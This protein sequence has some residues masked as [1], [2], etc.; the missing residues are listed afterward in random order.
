MPA[1]ERADG[2]WMS[3]STPIIQWFEAAYTTPAV[4]PQDPLQRFFS[5]L[6]E[7]YA[8][9]WLWRPAMHYRWHYEQGARL[10]SHYL[11]NE[12]GA[13]LPLPVFQKRGVI[14]RRQR[15]DYTTGDGITTDQVPGVEYHA[16]RLPG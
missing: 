7:D 1:L 4:I 9:E 16:G 3:D 12:I 5:L 15:N 8:D 2:R 14:T 13:E 11:A 6:L 10:A